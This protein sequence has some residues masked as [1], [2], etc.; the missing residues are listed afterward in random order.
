MTT[1][2]IILEK[3]RLNKPLLSKLGIRE[4]GLFGSYLRNENTISSDIDLLVDFDPEKETFDNFMA[5]YDLFE[6][7]FKNQKIE[8]V[9]TNGLSEH[10][11]SNILREVQ[12]V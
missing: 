6:S 3:L 12:Y 8:V 7:I 1:K 11:G 4:V 10:I 9:T 5:A 2:E